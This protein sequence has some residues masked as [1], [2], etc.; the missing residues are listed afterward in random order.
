MQVRGYRARPTDLGPVLESVAFVPPLVRI[1]RPSLDLAND[2]LDSSNNSPSREVLPETLVS[3]YESWIASGPL[4]VFSEEEGRQQACDASFRSLLK[5]IQE[6][7]HSACSAMLLNLANGGASAVTVPGREPNFLKDPRELLGLH[8]PN[9]AIRTPLLICSFVYRRDQV[10]VDG[11]EIN[12]FREVDPIPGEAQR[13]Q[14]VKEWLSS[15]LGKVVAHQLLRDPLE[16]FS[17]QGPVL[18]PPLLPKVNLQEIPRVVVVLSP[19]ATPVL[20]LCCRADE[21]RKQTQHLPG[22]SKLG[23][24]LLN[25]QFAA[26]Y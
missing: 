22:L 7:S 1:C 13:N 4:P 8:V 5:C 16:S 23:F 3:E 18:L 2:P 20:T 11:V 17:G 14:V 19:F 9:R 25:H 24:V 21:V 6:R 10:S 26:A 12:V 15:N